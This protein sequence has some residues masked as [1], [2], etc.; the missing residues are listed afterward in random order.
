MCVCYQNERV[1]YRKR[2]PNKKE[3]IRRSNECVAISL[4]IYVIKCIKLKG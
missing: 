2:K 3:R 4:C 1:K